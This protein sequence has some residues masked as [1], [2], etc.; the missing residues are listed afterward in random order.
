MTNGPQ[1]QKKGLSPLAWIAIG[2]GG[3]AVIGAIVAVIAFYFIGMKVKEVAEDFEKNPALSAAK[4]IDLAD[5]SVEIT[6]SDEAAQ[7]VTFVKTET[8]EEFV[9]SFED[10]E[11]GNLSWTT[12]EGTYGIN[13]SEVKEGGQ[14]TYS[15]P[16]G[17]TRL[18]TGSS[19]DIPQWVLLPPNAFNVE[20]SFSVT[21]ADLSTGA[22]SAKSRDSLDEVKSYYQEE[23]E[24]AGYEVSVTSYSAGGQRQDIVSGT[25]DGGKQVLN[26]AISLQE[27]QEV[28]VVVQ[29]QGPGKG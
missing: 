24:A 27:G 7:T 2:C 14:V 18:G 4:L 16:E 29:Y 19:A 11:N 1:T 12:S 26:A 3:L 13:A 28:Q 17:E 20:S 23:M 10:I 8:G 21:N 25:R 5:P 6:D 9:I 15:S 22:V